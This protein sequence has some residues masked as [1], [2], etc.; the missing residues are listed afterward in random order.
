MTLKQAVVSE[1]GEEELLAP[2]LIAVSLVANDQAK[3]Y[4]ALLQTAQENVERPQVPAP[5][6]KAERLA[7]QLTDDWL[8]D[9]VAGTRKDRGGA[10]R[11]PHGP[12]LLRRVR[13][14][15][16]TMLACLPEADRAPL[17]ARLAALEFPPLAHG[18]IPGALIQAMASGDRKAGDSLH[19]VVM[20][21]HR[22]INKLQAATAVETLAGARVHQLSDWGRPRVEA[23]MS[24][25]NRTAPLKFD[26]PG[27]GTTATEHN[28]ACSS[29]TTSARRTLTS[30]SCVSTTSP[31][32]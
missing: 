18:A 7:S 3:Y 24:G 10:Y 23:F 17:A 21:A 13:S 5:D 31:S 32:A 30:S 12:E 26:H 16:E 20:D 25:L 15:I 27:L 22:A 8:D 6:L 1:L 2:D 9:V 19:L 11:I 28:G 4:L 29:R 14:S